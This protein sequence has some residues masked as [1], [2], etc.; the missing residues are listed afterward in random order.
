M[1]S[2]NNSSPILN[3]V[4]FSGNSADN[5][6]GGMSNWT[7]SSPS[8]SNV[9]FSGNVAL[10]YGGGMYNY[11]DSSP[12]LNN[13][14]MSGNAAGNLGGGIVNWSGSYPTIDNSIFWQNQDN[15][16]IQATSQINNSGS[17]PVI[18]HTLIGG[19][20]GRGRDYSP[21]LYLNC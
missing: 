8:L 7:N 11:N 5:S 10:Y 19:S 1:Y 2:E 20:G 12:T 17:I 21:H 13:V 9:I 3:N 15:A 18:R 4:S 6:G 14:T 16:G